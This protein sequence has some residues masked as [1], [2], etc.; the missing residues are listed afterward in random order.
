MADPF[1]AIRTQLQSVRGVLWDFDGCV[2]DSE[3]WH[4]RAYGAAFQKYGHTIP[5]RTYYES[6]SHRGDSAEDEILRAG[7]PCT[8][9]E[10][11]G[12]KNT[13][14]TRFLDHNDVKPFTELPEILS[15][16]NR[17]NIKSVVASNSPKEQ[18]EAILKRHNLLSA[19]AGVV[20]ADAQLRKKPFPDVFLR[21]GE[22]LDLPKENLLIFEDS[23]RGFKAAAAA[24][25]PVVWL[26][27]PRNEGFST[28]LPYLG[29]LR[30]F[31]VVQLLK[32]LLG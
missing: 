7:L 28:Q 21:A 23:E 31:E 2:V 32:S 27:T 20:G 1:L 10:I 24:S 16:L 4:W 26:R 22:F 9:N 17:L 3:P 15:L 6:F 29:E 19:F 12:I 18:I 30:H 11:R 13:H 25:I 14:Y 8:A 5:E